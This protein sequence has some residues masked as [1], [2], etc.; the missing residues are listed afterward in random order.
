MNVARHFENAVQDGVIDVPANRDRRLASGKRGC[1]LFHRLGTVL[2]EDDPRRN[3]LVWAGTGNQRCGE[4]AFGLSPWIDPSFALFCGALEVFIDGTR[5]TTKPLS[6]V[7]ENPPSLSHLLLR[8]P[9][10]AVASFFN[11]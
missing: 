3:R 11:C 8:E 9:L 10:G 6:C 2:T 1:E 7:G 5:G 4:Q